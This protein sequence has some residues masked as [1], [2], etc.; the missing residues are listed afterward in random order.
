M[1]FGKMRFR[2]PDTA[3]TLL[4]ELLLEGNDIDASPRFEGEGRGADYLARPGSTWQ[5]PLSMDMPTRKDIE[6]LLKGS[7]ITMEWHELDRFTGA[8]I[9]RRSEEFIEVTI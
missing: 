3:V 7:G 9:V 8:S 2:D 5:P 4:Q 6:A 1:N